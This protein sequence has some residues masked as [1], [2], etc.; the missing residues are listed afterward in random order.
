MKAVVQVTAVLSFVA[1]VCFAEEQTVVDLTAKPVKVAMF[2]MVWGWSP[3]RWN[4]PKP[5]GITGS[6]PCRT[7]HSAV[8]GSA[9]RKPSL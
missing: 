5:P 8:S 7:P 1:C 3:R 9:G 4:C 2:K 6:V